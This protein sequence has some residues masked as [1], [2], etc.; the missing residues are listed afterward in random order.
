MDRGS[1]SWVAGRH[2]IQAPSAVRSLH[3]HLVGAA[4]PD[5]GPGFSERGFLARQEIFLMPPPP[6]PPPPE[7]PRRLAGG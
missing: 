2:P 5:K 7:P 1:G 4:L 3:S 6:P